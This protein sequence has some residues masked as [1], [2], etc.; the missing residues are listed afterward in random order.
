MSE[1]EQ[2]QSFPSIRHADGRICRY[3]PYALDGVRGLRHAYFYGEPPDMRRCL[4]E[5]GLEDTEDEGEQL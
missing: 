4:R 1:S 5:H 2:P 3:L